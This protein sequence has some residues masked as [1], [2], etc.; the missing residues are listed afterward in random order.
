MTCV[1]LGK[2]CY[3]PKSLAQQDKGT[4]TPSVKNFPNI[5]LRREMGDAVHDVAMY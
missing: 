3:L 5:P 4:R 2:E 1:H